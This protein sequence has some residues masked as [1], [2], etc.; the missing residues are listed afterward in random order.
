LWASYASTGDAEHT[1]SPGI[2]RAFDASD[3]TKELWNN[4]QTAGDYA[5]NYAKFSSPTIANGHVY[6]PT[7][8]G[9]VVVYGIK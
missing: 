1:V 4:N 8:S 3:V 7:F 9:Q 6:L 5:G 2:L